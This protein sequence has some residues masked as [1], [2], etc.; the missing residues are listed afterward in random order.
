[1][2]SIPLFREF[3]SSQVDNDMYRLQTIHL[4]QFTH[5]L[6]EIQS[7]HYC[8]YPGPTVSPCYLVLRRIISLTFHFN[9][10]P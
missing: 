9:Y 8:G 10:F 2:E 3:L 1:M 5:V 6:S 4:V 7:Y